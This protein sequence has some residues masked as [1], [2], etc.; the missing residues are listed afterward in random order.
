MRCHDRSE[1]EHLLVH[2]L[3]LVHHLVPKWSL[4]RRRSIG[5]TT[6][7]HKE[8][9]SEKLNPSAGNKVEVGGK[10]SIPGGREGVDA[11]GF[12]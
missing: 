6:H 3:Q 10:H 9:A 8:R 12:N 11:A 7:A 1:F 5:K 2:R 4:H